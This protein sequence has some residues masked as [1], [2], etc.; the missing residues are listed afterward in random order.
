MGLVGLAVSLGL[1]RLAADTVEIPTWIGT[2]V[3]YLLGGGWLVFYT[4]RVQKRIQEATGQ[5][6]EAE[7][8]EIYERVARQAGEQLLALRT[9]LNSAHKEAELARSETKRIQA[10]RDAIVTRLEHR[11]KELE[12]ELATTRAEVGL[13]ERRKKPPVKRRNVN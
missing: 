6:T 13:D 1:G 3:P 10:E 4:A 11:I 7:A 5:R 9:Q 2:L 8:D 12:E